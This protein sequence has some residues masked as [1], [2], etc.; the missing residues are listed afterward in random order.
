MASQ[1]SLPPEVLRRAKE[2]AAADAPAPAADA[3]G[4]DA[5]EE[6]A[7]RADFF[8]AVEYVNTQALQLSDDA[9]RKLFGLHCVATNGAPPP[10]DSPSF[11]TLYENMPESE[12]AKDAAWRSAHEEHPQ[13]LSAMRA[14]VDLVTREVP[15]F[16]LMAPEE[17]ASDDQLRKVK[18]DLSACG[19]N[20]A[21]APPP[22]PARDVFEAARAGAA[23]LK[24][25]GGDLSTDVNKVDDYHLTP[26]IHAVDA[27]REDSAR[28]LLDA[29]ADLNQSDDDGSTPL[30]YAALLG[31]IPLATLLA[32]RGADRSLTDGDGNTAGDVARSEGHTAIAEL[33]ATLK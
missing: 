28:L 19:I 15:D 30:H 1:I 27:E 14:Y 24:A 21:D 25:F 26:L 32:D 13:Q 20:E 6:Q 22:P 8:E 12:R 29:G 23:S 17:D 5:A 18:N 11:R 31:S 4:M 16:L 33:L 7:T 9:Q 10:N 3:S 2:A